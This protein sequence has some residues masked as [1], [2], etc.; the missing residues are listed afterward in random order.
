LNIDQIAEVF[1]PGGFLSQ[2]SGYEYRPQQVELSRAVHGNTGHLMSEAPAGTGKSWSY[3]VPTIDKAIQEGKPAVICTATIALQEQLMDDIES[4]K[5]LFPGLKATLLKGKSHFVCPLL[6]D[7]KRKDERNKYLGEHVTLWEMWQDGLYDRAYVPRHLL[8]A[9]E[10]VNASNCVKDRGCRVCPLRNVRQAAVHSNLIVTSHAL[11]LSHLKA[12]AFSK[13]LPDFR[14]IVID[15]AHRFADNLSEL[16]SFGLTTDRPQAFE[17]MDQLRRDTSIEHPLRAH[18]KHAMTMGEQVRREE[19]PAMLVTSKRWLNLC[20]DVAPTVSRLRDEASRVDKLC[21]RLQGDVDQLALAVE[22]HQELDRLADRY[23]RFFQTDRNVRW[24]DHRGV[25]YAPLEVA[26]WLEA[27]L[28]RKCS[29]T[30]VSATLQ[31]IG[32][33]DRKTLGLPPGPELVLDTPFN[34]KKQCLLALTSGVDPDHEEHPDRVAIILREL[35]ACLGGSILC[36]FTSY[37]SMQTVATRLF[38]EGIPHLVQGQDGE[39]GQLIE[40]FKEGGTILLGTSTF[41]EGIDLVGD[42]LRALVIARLPF[43]VPTDP[44]HRARSELY[45][46]P[47]YEYTLSR[48]VTRIRQGFGRL[49]RTRSDRGVCVIM[50]SR[51]TTK[52]YGKLILNSLP[53]CTIYRGGGL[54]AAVREWLSL[55]NQTLVA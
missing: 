16:L 18:V 46:H 24:I 54:R 1:K 20:H 37:A 33:F 30:L 48:T 52:Q 27:K 43:D 15:E 26:G 7:R 42:Y 25:H 10:T 12:G 31:S 45:K 47:F 19:D 32:G 2:R 39:R 23:E 5:G 6:L 4:L 9:F 22:T 13:V 29:S 28:W 35:Y 51:L 17:L 40:R 44:V 38:V 8:R 49:I 21:E 3:L 50:D 41:W 11:V 14:R 55:P 36:L 34:F 53:E